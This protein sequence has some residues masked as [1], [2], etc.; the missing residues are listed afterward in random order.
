MKEFKW[1]L[2]TTNACILYIC[3]TKRDLLKPLTSGTFHGKIKTTSSRQY[4]RFWAM[5]KYSH[6]MLTKKWRTKTAKPIES[7]GERTRITT[8]RDGK[9]S[10]DATTRWYSE[11]CKINVYKMN[12]YFKFWKMYVCVFVWNR[13]IVEAVLSQLLVPSFVLNRCMANHVHEYI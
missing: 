2:V 12:Y 1:K 4:T 7:I 9:K 3:Y 5:N 8:T 11:Q 13:P 6:N 10:S